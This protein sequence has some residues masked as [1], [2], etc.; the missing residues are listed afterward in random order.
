MR[1]RPL[2]ARPGSVRAG[3]VQRYQTVLRYPNSNI[4]D[5]FGSRLASTVVPRADG[6]APVR[7]SALAKSSFGGPVSRAKDAVTAFTSSI[8]TVQAPRPEQAPPHPVNV[9]V[10]AGVG[11]SVT[12]ERAG[13]NARPILHWTTQA[14]PAGEL[15][16]VPEPVPRASSTASIPV[17]STRTKN[18]STSSRPKLNGAPALLDTWRWYVTPAR[19]VQKAARAGPPSA[20]HVAC[21]SKGTKEPAARLFVWTKTRLPPRP[22]ASSRRVPLVGAALVD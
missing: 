6:E 13:N 20:G 8:V 17:L 10:G 11:V 12:V 7:V 15:E 5:S 9:L 2:A 1:R 19:T 4:D 18:P 22:Q 21:S 14:K 16:T 3:T